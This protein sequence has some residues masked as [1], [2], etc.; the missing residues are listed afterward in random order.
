MP[1]RQFNQLV[2]YMKRLKAVEE[3][4]E[5]EGMMLKPPVVHNIEG[6]VLTVCYDQIPNGSEMF[7]NRP[8]DQ[9]HYTVQGMRISGRAYE[10][11]CGQLCQGL[12]FIHRTCNVPVS[13]FQN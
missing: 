9:F 7:I 8:T 5:R 2:A 3:R 1:Y 13:S 4:R 11:L 10:E 6:M 12:D